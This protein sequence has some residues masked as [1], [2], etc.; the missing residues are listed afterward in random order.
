VIKN[1]NRRALR[2]RVSELPALSPDGEQ[3]AYFSGLPDGIRI[4]EVRKGKTIR[5]IS[6][7]LGVSPALFFPKPGQ[8]LVIEFGNTQQAVV[9]NIDSGQSA[10]SSP[11]WGLEDQ[12]GL[13]ALSPGGRF[14][15]VAAKDQGEL[16]DVIRFID[17]S[18]GEVAAEIVP[19]GRGGRVPPQVSALAFS[20]DGQEFAV[21]AGLPDSANLL[22][23]APTLLI[24]NLTTGQETDRVVIETGGRGQITTM[25]TPEPLQ[26]FPDQKAFLVMQQLVSDRATGKLLDVV[27]A[28]G[29]VNA[30]FATKIL[31]DR[32]VI[33]AAH[34]QK[35]TVR[36][37]HRTASR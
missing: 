36:T 25:I 27:P 9:W 28:E 5:Q 19:G 14:L 2:S 10:V 20:P 33:T 15:A 26:W 37:V 22:A 21:L 23:V 29:S 7:D 16:P 30:H 35:L 18:T 6:V 13:F 17:L 34:Q 4:V 1:V 31:D 3:L 32:R 24:W 8:L 11:L 12:P